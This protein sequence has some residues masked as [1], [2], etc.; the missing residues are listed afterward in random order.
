MLHNIYMKAKTNDVKAYHIGLA[1]I[2]SNDTLKTI[3]GLDCSK[4]YM[5]DKL[6]KKKYCYCCTTIPILYNLLQYE[7]V[8]RTTLL[9][10]Y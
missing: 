7:L 5:G 1:C 3:I 6:D 4:G 2:L 9:L 10:L 8:T